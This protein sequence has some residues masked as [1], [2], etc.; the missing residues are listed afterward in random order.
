MAANTLENL[1]ME[2]KRLSFKH[3]N[4]KF[5]YYVLNYLRQ[6]KPSIYYQKKL[7]KKLMELDDFDMEKILSRV[8]YYNK[9]DDVKTL[10]NT[11]SLAD[12]KIEKGSKAYFFDLYEY[13]R[14][15]H[16]NLK[17]H[18]LFGDITHIPNDP[19]LVKSRPISD[20][21][22]NS[23][24][25]KWNKVRHFTYVKIDKDYLTKKNLMV[26]RGKVRLLQSHRIRFLTMYYKHPMCNIARVNKNELST[27]WLG[28]RMTIDEQLDYKFILSLEGNDVASN[29]KWVMSS[30]S[31]AVMPKPKFET[32]FMEG[33]L[34]PNYHYILI[35]DD[36]SDVEEQLNYYIENPQKA[37]EI[38]KN[39][40]KYV[41]QFKDKSSEDLIS[42]I[43]LKKYFEKTNQL[44]LH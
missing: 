25:L 40:N 42:L 8:N 12:L 37:K 29:L 44:L 24:L 6:L 38:I 7:E 17:G 26:W 22:E 11:V 13:G 31:V 34:I 41:E 4:N 30:N 10:S 39:A 1:N 14:F 36:Y 20:K 35:K 16:K 43:V 2:I 19:S 28:G 23:I 5:Y 33:L 32:W 27:E 18:F 15:F 21:N 9:L 3:K